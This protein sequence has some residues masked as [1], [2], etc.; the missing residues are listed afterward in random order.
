MP[1]PVAAVRAKGLRTRIRFLLRDDFTDTLSAGSVN[2]TLATDGVNLRTVADA[3]LKISTSLGKLVFSSGKASPS[4]TDPM[5][6]YPSVTRAAK[7]GLFVK[8]ATTNRTRPGL[9]NALTGGGATQGAI[10]NVQGG[11]TIAV[12]NG[13]T[14]P[15]VGAITSGTEYQYC[16]VCRLTGGF[17][18]VRGGTQYPLATL[19]YPD[20]N[21]TTTPLYPSNSNYDGTPNMDTFRIHSPVTITPLA[22]DA[23][24]RAN[25]ALGNTGGGGSEETGGSGLAWTDQAGTWGIATNAAACSALAGGIGIATVPCGS[26]NVIVEC[27]VTRS[28]GNAGIVARYSDADSYIYAYHDGTNAHLNKVTAAGG[29]QSLINAAATYSAGARLILS[30]SG[31]AVRLWYNGA[32][33]GAQQTISDAELQTGT[34]HGLFTSN[35]GNS[36][37]N[38]VVWA[39]GNA[40]EY[41]SIFNKVFF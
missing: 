29:D 33:V 34:A 36:L 28:A 19:L 10:F 39:R 17:Y 38:F 16:I 13:T 21:G 37:D 31:T 35:T 2:N 8:S 5:L 30:L 4:Q 12:A 18:L 6:S 26:V 20:K 9:R 23:F 1:Y 3:E 27:A 40:S 24:A 15:V 41:E 11:N 7:L 14:N 32:L 22:S 25:G